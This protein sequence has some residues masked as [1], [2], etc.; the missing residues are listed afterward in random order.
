MTS[1]ALVV[2]LSDGLIEAH[3]HFFVMVAVVALYQSWQPY[4]LA[5]AFVVVHHSVDRH[6]CRPTLSTTIPPRLT[7]PG[8]GA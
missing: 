1:S 3:F 6:L 2:H 8:C 7:T 5:L 4:L